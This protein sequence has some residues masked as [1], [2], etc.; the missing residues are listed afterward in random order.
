MS[1]QYQKPKSAAKQIIARG[2]K[3]IK[4]VQETMALTSNIVG[5]TLGPGGRP[6][7]IERFEHGLPPMITK[8]GVTVF[9]ALGMTDP[10]AHCIMEAARDAATKTAVEAGDGTTTATVLAESIFR[11]TMEFCKANP[12]ISPQ[13]VVRRLEKIFETHLRKMIQENAI[14]ASLENENGRFILETVATVS[15]NG[16][17]EL[18]KA[19]LE[20]FDL[21][22]DEGNVTIS[23]VSGP[24]STYEVEAINGYGV[25][26]VGYEQSCAKYYPNFVNDPGNQRCVMEKPVFIVY[27]GRVSEMQ[28]IVNLLMKIGSAWGEGEYKHHN[29]VLVATGFSETVLSTLA[30]NFPEKVSINVFPLVAPLSPV[31]SGQLHFLQDVCAITGAKLFDPMNNPLDNAELYDLGPGVELFESFRG[32]SNIIG[33]AKGECL[34]GSGETYE[35]RLLEHVSNLEIQ[36]ENPESELD[37]KLIQERLGKCTGGIAKLKVVG[38]SNGEIKEKRDRAEDAVCAVR[39]AIAHGCLPGGAWMLI[40][41]SEYLYDNFK[42][43]EILLNVL[44]PALVEPFFRILHNVGIDGEEAE[45][46]YQTLVAEMNADNCVVYD[47]REHN[48]VNPLDGVLDSLPAVLEAIKNSISIAGLLG[49]LGG[50]VVFYRDNELDRREAIDTQEFIRNA[51]VNPADENP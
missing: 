41:L 25:P 19:V 22:G 38:S 34:D 17:T 18:A 1:F 49:T 24:K 4:L 6:V 9:K 36:L 33:H 39:G 14:H 31:P 32:R 43:D 23:E 30:L 44:V 37:K 11:R 46:I 47:A 15:A 5:G 42:E 12:K 35:D 40:K 16:D 27:H 10:A 29:V 7:L 26:T 13:K 50:T 28:T 3:L 21:V 45:D 8:D 20:C 51:N 2:D 48:Y